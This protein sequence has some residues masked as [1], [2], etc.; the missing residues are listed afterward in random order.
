[1]CG[2]D[3]CGLGCGPVTGACEHD[4][5]PWVSMKGGKFLD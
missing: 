2:L 3:A 5:E 1:M 4:Y